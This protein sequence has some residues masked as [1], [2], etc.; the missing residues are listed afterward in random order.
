M[1]R[2]TVDNE[3]VKK[4]ITTRNQESLEALKQRLGF[5]ETGLTKAEVQTGH[6]RGAPGSECN[7]R[8]LGGVSGRQYHP[9]P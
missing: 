1:S 7:N 3:V 9:S 2:K 8:L 5:T 4:E 6:N